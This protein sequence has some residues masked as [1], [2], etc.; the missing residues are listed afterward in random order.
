LEEDEV[1]EQTSPTLPLSLVT[2]V[3]QL[4][5]VWVDADFA[6]SSS[7]ERPQN[8]GKDSSMSNGAGPDGVIRTSSM[9]TS[10]S[11]RKSNTLHGL[12]LKRTNTYYSDSQGPMATLERWVNSPHFESAF[13]ALIVLNTLVMAVEAQY[14]GIDS[15]YNL[16]Y[17]GSNAA[18]TD[19][20]P[21]ADT[22]FEG[23]EWF[24]GI[25]FSVELLFKLITLRKRFC[26]EFWNM[27]DFTIVA[28]WLF[29]SLGTVQLPIDPML[30][31]LARLARLLRLLK[32]VH[33]IQACDSLYLM[34]TA[35]TGSMSVL[36]WSVGILVIVQ[37]MIAFVL[38]Q[39]LESYVKDESNS[40]DQRM[41]VFKFYGTFARTMLTMFEITLGN[42]MPPCRA[43]VENVSEW[44]M[45]FSLT[46]KLVI[47]FSV[48]SVITGVFIQETFKVATTDDRIMV[49]SKERARSTHTKKMTALFNSADADGSGFIDYDEYAEIFTNP[50]VKTW[51]SAME[52]DVSDLEMIFELLDTDRD[53]RLRLSDLI[54]G[55]SRLKGNARN[56]DMMALHH[57]NHELMDLI[58]KIEARLSAHM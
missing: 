48:V 23:A 47:G 21:W 36:F 55:V 27:V 53:G 49:M 50:E 9:S 45:L 15:G 58:G 22:F 51:L 29:S 39:L 6:S 57:R 41:E 2:E 11:T 24:F 40:E 28:A 37:M 52:L 25:I 46:H 30:L 16:G 17:P 38:Q 18:A 54:D 12:Q 31:R 43:L 44:Y 5:S 32:L 8:E 4:G 20:W 1:I 42:W 34:T 13:A 7:P 10:P 14:R 26:Y 56:T 3:D 35:M 19:V 33:S